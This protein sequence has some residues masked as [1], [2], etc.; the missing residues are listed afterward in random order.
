M[1]ENLVICRVT[2][3]EKEWLL[4]LRFTNR[5][6]VLNLVLPSIYLIDKDSENIVIVE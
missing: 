4:P 1:A 2:I 3:K 6:K 5:I